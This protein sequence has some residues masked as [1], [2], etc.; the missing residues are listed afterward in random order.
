MRNDFEFKGVRLSSFGGWVCESMSIIRGKDKVETVK[1]AGS[2]RILHVR[3]SEDAM[4]NVTIPIRCVVPAGA[5]LDAIFAWLRGD[6]RLIRSCDEAH[7]H[8][9]FALSGIEMERV[10]PGSGIRR[11]TVNFDCDPRRFLWPQP[12]TQI[13]S[14]PGRIRNDGSGRCEPLIRVYGAQGLE[15][16]TLMVG[17]H[18]MVIDHAGTML[19]LDCDARL[20]IDKDGKLRNSDVMRVG[21]WIQIAAGG[22][23]C[24]WSGGI[25]RVE[26]E[27]NAWDY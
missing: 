2:S 20:A 11:F 26:V 25:D 13:L 6:G 27:T 24:S 3:E 12:Q 9:A 15:G 23:M 8:R 10:I 7:F 21:D 22:D 1:I 19:T 18:S 17:N 16:C 14:S 5:D 4:D